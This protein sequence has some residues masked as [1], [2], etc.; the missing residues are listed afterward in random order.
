MHRR[1]IRPILFAGAIA[2]AACGGT[3]PPTPFPSPV[4]LTTHRAPTTVPLEGTPAP[5]G[6]TTATPDPLSDLAI[7]SLTNRSYGGGQIEFE[8]DPT[9]SGSFDRYLFNYPS[10][11]LTIY[12]FMDVPRRAGPLPVVLVLHGYLDPEDYEIHPYT[13]RYVDSLAASGFVALHPNFRNYAPS[14]SGP[15][16][17]RVGSAID[18]LNLIALVRQQAG[19]PGPLTSADGE[20][21]GLFGHSMGGGIALRVLTVGAPVRAAVLYASMN[22]DEQLNFES[23]FEWSEGQRGMEEL[24]VAPSELLHIS[25][26]YYLDRIGVPLSIHHGEADELVPPEWSDE[27]CQ[28]MRLLGK[29][30]ECFRYPNEQ[31]TFIGFGGIELMERAV[32]FFDRYLATP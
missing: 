24:Q 23:I 1:P 15:N 2:L 6:P 9:D 22:A 10:D 8:P 11:G 3:V 21:I 29:T 18:V 13:T 5:A 4:V 12:G 25:P 32:D 30:V 7:D 26:V 16:L 31:H 27:L 19:T 17:F 14:D 20:A 28:R